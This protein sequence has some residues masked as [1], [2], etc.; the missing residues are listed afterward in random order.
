[1]SKEPPTLTDARLSS[2]AERLDARSTRSVKLDG[3]QVGTVYRVDFED[4][5]SIAVKVS[6]VPLENEARMLTYLDEE[7]PLPVPAVVSVDPDLLALEFVEGDGRFDAAVERD[8]AEHLAALHDVSAE[9]FGFGFETLSGPYCQP[10]PWTDSWIEFF[11]EQRLLHFAEKARQEGV[12]PQ[13]YHRRVHTLAD[14][15]DDLLIEPDAP[16][17]VHN[18]FHDAN[19]IVGDGRVKAVLDPAIYFAHDELELAYVEYV[20]VF[21]DPFFD[22]YRQLRDIDDDFF[23]TRRDVYTAFHVLE[24]VRFFGERLLDQLDDALD[25]IGV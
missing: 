7:T 13:S 14:R 16:S 1:M 3:G 9:A 6:D 5:P 23:E 2:L 25:R 12:L 15:L 4:R 11:R 10:N 20:D 8:A 17:I 24:N 22:R 21:G 19:M 18:D